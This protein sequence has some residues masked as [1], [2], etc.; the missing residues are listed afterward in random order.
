MPFLGQ[1]RADHGSA[2]ASLFAD[3]VLVASASDFPVTIP[4]NPLWGIGAGVTRWFPYGLVHDYPAWPD[5]TGMLWPEE[6]ATVDQMIRSFT[7]NG[8]RADFLERTTGSIE[9]GKSGDL[10]VLDQ[11]LFQISPD[12]IFDGSVL[13]TV[14]QGQTLYDAGVL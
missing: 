13:R 8:A 7:T 5:P 14:F 6:A 4:P 9:V 11:N 12:T 10:I 3:C 1:P 2:M